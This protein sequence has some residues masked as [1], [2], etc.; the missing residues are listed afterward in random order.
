MSPI[1]RATLERM[2]LK[3]TKIPH[4]TRCQR[5]GYDL[6]GLDPLGLCPECGSRVELALKPDYLIYSAPEYVAKNSL[7]K[8]PTLELDDG[9]F[10]SESV[11]ICRW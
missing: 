3:N 9:T 5:C 4:G 6:T 10:L 8:V 2:A 1:D 7:A 11:S